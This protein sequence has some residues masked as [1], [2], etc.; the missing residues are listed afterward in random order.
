MR[1]V[2]AERT[3]RGWDGVAREEEVLCFG[4]RSASVIRD[5]GHM[6]RMGLPSSLSA[7]S[8]GPPKASA[9]F[10]CQICG[11]WMSCEDDL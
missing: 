4:I 9:G 7:A 10:T 3:E 1:V 8:E 5:F 11:D 6:P 2:E